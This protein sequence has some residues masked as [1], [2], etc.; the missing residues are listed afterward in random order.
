MTKKTSESAVNLLQLKVDFHCGDFF[1]R[2]QENNAG[3]C[4]SGL[5]KFIQKK[6]VTATPSYLWQEEMCGSQMSVLFPLPSF[7]MYS[8]AD[9]KVKPSESC[10]GSAVIARP[11]AERHKAPSPER[12]PWR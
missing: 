7:P 3:A 1:R 9:Q 4:S 2:N 10:T 5:Q 6:P 12:H 11:E 8:F